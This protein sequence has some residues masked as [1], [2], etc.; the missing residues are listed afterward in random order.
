MLIKTA[1]ALT[2]SQARD[3]SAKE[4]SRL[5]MLASEFADAIGEC[6]D[7]MAKWLGFDDGGTVTITGNIDDISDPANSID[8]LLQLYVTGI[9]SRETVFNEAKRRNIIS[10]TVD[11]GEETEKIALDNGI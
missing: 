4:R 10:D 3:E 2:D 11:Y 7:F 6:L 5:S 9:V 1:V 8:T